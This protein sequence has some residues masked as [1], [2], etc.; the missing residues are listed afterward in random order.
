MSLPPLLNATTN[1]GAIFNNAGTLTLNNTL[2]V[3]NT[4]TAATQVAGIFTNNTSFIG[5]APVTWLGPLQNNGGLISTHA[6]LATAPVGAAGVINAG[7]NANALNAITGAALTTDQRGTQFGQ[8]YAR[9]VNGTVDIGA[10]EYG[11][12]I[13]GQKFND[14]NGNGVK[15]GTDATVTTP[16]Q[17]FVIYSDDNNNNAPDATEKQ[18][19]VA[20]G[21]T[22]TLADTK[23]NSP[24]KEVAVTG[25]QQTLPA[26]GATPYNTGVADAAA[27][28]FGNFQLT[29]IAGKTYTDL[30]GNGVLD[31]PTDTTLNGVTVNLY[32]D[33]NADGI[34][35]T[36]TDT[37]VGTAQTTAGA[38]DYLF[39]D[40]GPGSYLIEA[41]PPA[42]SSIS[43]PAIPIA[44]T[45]QSGTPIVD[46]NFGIFQNITVSG[47]KFNDLNANG[48]LDAGEPGL[49]G[50]QISLE[51]TGFIT[52]A[53]PLTATTDPSGNY[54]IANVGPGTYRLRETLQA[55][56]QQTFP[57]PPAV[58]TITP[59]SGTNITNTAA[60]PTNFGNFQ[61]GSI[62]GIKFNDI[63]SDG[64]RQP[65][66]PPLGGWRIYLDANTNGTF[67][68]GE[69]NQVTDATGLYE[70][71]NLAGGTYTVREELQTGW[72][73]TA[74]AAPGS[75]SVAIQSGTDSQNNNF[76]NFRANSISG[77][78]FNDLNSNGILE[79]GEPPLG[80]W[81]IYLD[82]NGNNVLDAGE[83][84]T[85]TDATTGQYTF[86]GL[87][88]GSYRVREVQQPTWTQS[89][90]N[91]GAINVTSGQDITG[92]N[93][94]N[95]Q[96][97][98]ISGTK[99]ND[100]NSNGVRDDGEPG[101][102]NWQIFLDLNGDNLFQPNEPD[103][104][105]DASGN[106]TLANIAP[107][108]YKVR[109]VLQNGWRQTTPN[110]PDVVVAPTSA[111]TGIN[112][113][114]FNTQTPT[115]TPTPAPTP[116]PTPEPTPTPTPTPATP[117]PTPAFTPV[118]EPDTGCDCQPLP[119]VPP[120]TFFQPQSR[121]IVNFDSNLA[122]FINI[123]NS[124][125][126]TP[127]NDSLTGSDLNELFVA[128]FGDDTA[129]GGGGADIA[130]GDQD[131]D[132]ISAEKG[133]DI[134]YAGKELMRSLAETARSNVWRSRFRHAVRRSR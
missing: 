60:L 119:L 25:W 50:W 44:V 23:T 20:I 38:G 67:D 108:T 51:P 75:Y 57:V 87:L 9:T 82:T 10:Y 86:T 18:T 37:V 78:K 4:Q 26:T 45:A 77:I 88:A 36:A 84:S 91:S 80:N 95:F 2:V 28:D 33:T 93:F 13:T 11:P 110:P 15:D 115:P 99:F 122:D 120:V 72:T 124:I 94:G 73:Q 114:N 83:T 104:I 123:Q 40:I 21:G 39:S 14:S 76:G 1:G 132:F 17:N 127:S 59:A 71:V 43:F 5:T 111:V 98:S 117:T 107:G 54:T 42:G 126:G 90:T 69:I 125:L 34:L 97:A 47:Q 49:P 58:T 68:A 131:R 41:V 64:I 22:Y 102:S 92:V 56:W 129:I 70:F 46:R 55:G 101:L 79:A 53:V 16:A 103:N 30:A 27:R 121:P 96:T 100:R 3:N 65:A 105:T 63:N 52:T 61:L 106:Y 8:P 74:P 116:A 133:D 134:V 81:Q 66:E 85:R 62:S 29:T 35:Q 31:L 89:T 19:T 32:R 130:F 109:E 24:I 48:I 12:T 128:F 118:P 7:T 113:G 6:L 112:F